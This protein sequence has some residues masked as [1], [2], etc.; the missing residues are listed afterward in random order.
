MEVYSFDCVTAAAEDLFGKRWSQISPIFNKDWSN[1]KEPDS[2]AE[3]NDIWYR[4]SMNYKRAIFEN[5]KNAKQFVDP[6]ISLEKNFEKADSDSQYGGTADVYHY[7]GPLG[8]SYAIKIFQTGTSWAA[9]NH[10][11][12]I[13]LALKHANIVKVHH[14]VAKVVD[15]KTIYHLVMEYVNGKNLSKLGKV[16]TENNITQAE[17]ALKHMA[18]RQ[19]WPGDLH[20]RN[21]MLDAKKNLK[22]IDL[23][24]YYDPDVKVE[25]DEK[26]SSSENQVITVNLRS[27][28]AD[29]DDVAFGDFEDL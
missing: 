11:F 17:A 20:T 14:C 24:L 7:R 10:E 4:Q 6:N 21:T 13:G 12:G 29:G 22:F 1:T 2:L 3:I 26:E 19:I 5:G 23:G 25:S 27:S 28:K 16:L 8:Q 15:E 9:V 18:Q